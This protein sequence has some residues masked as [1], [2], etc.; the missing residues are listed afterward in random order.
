MVLVGGMVYGE[1][2]LSMPAEI[3]LV[4]NTGQQY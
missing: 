1:F 2:E 3:L 4:L